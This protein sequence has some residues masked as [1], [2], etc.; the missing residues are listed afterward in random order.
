VITA[1]Y[2]DKVHFSFQR[3]VSNQ[4]RERF[5]FE[6]TPLRIHYRPRTKRNPVP[7]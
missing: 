2:P 4:I 3:Y 7:E 1:N 5:G 6:G